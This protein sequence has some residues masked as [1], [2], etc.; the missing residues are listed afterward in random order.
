MKVI[1]SEV[2]STREF[3][4]LLALLVGAASGSFFGRALKVLGYNRT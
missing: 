1:N 4:A 3:I 2:Y